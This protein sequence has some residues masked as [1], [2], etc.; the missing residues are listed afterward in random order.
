[1]ITF[2]DHPKLEGVKNISHETAMIQSDQEALVSA[3]KQHNK[4][5]RL[6]C[7]IVYLG[8]NSL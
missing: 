2:T 6:K 7:M 1:M 8:E 4:I 5:L 3:S